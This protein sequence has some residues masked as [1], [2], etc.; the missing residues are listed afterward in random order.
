MSKRYIDN[1]DRALIGIDKFHYAP[2]VTDTPE[3]LEYGPMVEFP[4][5]IE[6]SVA[7]NSEVTSLYADNKPAIIYSTMGNVELSM[8]KT[9][10]PNEVLG[11]WLGSPMAGGTRHITS[12]QNAPYFGVAWRQ[13]YSDGKYAY[14]KLYKGKFTEPDKN[15]TT[16]EESIE[17]QT[18]EI[19]AQ[20]ASTIHE[21]DGTVDEVDVK[22][23]LL[24]SI[25]EEDSPSYTDEGKTWFDA[26]YTTPLP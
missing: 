19:T 11:E 2:L 26:I 22:F 20:F 21:V 5:T 24:M 6:M 25:A 17:F 15:A 12:T 10:I 23:P 18:A 3:T 7:T 9:T 4:N 8:T 16:K 13:L 14:V 1:T